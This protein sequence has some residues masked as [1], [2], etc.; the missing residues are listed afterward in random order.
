MHISDENGKPIDEIL[1]YDWSFIDITSHGVLARCIDNTLIDV[2]GK[3]AINFDKE[4][5]SCTTNTQRN[6]IAKRYF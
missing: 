3:E 5:N 4:W 6:R 2:L 1:K